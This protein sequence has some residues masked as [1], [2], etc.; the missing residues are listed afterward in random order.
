MLGI[1][2]FSSGMALLMRQIRHMSEIT[3][4]SYSAYI[5]VVCLGKINLFQL[6]KNLST[7]ISYSLIG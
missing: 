2:I 3:I 5:T 1:P 7:Q 6:M 4:S